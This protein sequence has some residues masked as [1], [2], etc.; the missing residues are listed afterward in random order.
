MHQ[1]ASA[2][3]A[4]RLGAKV[5]GEEVQDHSDRQGQQV[6]SDYWPLATEIRNLFL[7]FIEYTLFGYDESALAQKGG[8][9][10]ECTWDKHLEYFGN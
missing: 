9:H 6:T 7:L 10:W 2:Y 3:S 5:I 4:R 1:T 8:I